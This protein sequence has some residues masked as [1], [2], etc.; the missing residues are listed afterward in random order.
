MYLSKLAVNPV[1]N[2][3]VTEITSRRVAENKHLPRREIKQ[4]LR[5]YDRALSATS[6]GIVIAD[7]QQP[8]YPLIYCNPAFEKLTGYSKEEVLGFNCRFLQ[9]VDSDPEVIEEIRSCLEQKKDCAVVVKNYRKDGTPFWNELTISP[10]RD[11]KG[12]V[13]HFIGVQNDITQRKLAEEALQKANQELEQR[14]E[15]RTAALQQANEMLKK[16]IAERKRVEAALRESEARFRAIFERAAIG[17]ALIDMD[18]RPVVS[19]PALQKMLGYSSAELGSMTFAEFTHPNDVTNDSEEYQQL[20]TGN[21]E[22]YQKSKRYYR[23]DRKLVWGN[24]SISLVRDSKGKPQFAV[25]MVENITKRKQAEVALHKALVKE[26]ELGEL[27]SKII[28]IT[29]HEFRTPLTTILSSAELLE[30]YSQEWNEAKKLKHIQRI[31]MTVSQMTRVLDDVLLL[32]KAEAGKLKFTP[33]PL[34]LVSFCYQAIEELRLG[35]GSR[36]LLNFFFDQKCEPALIDEKLLRYILSNLFSNAVKYSPEGSTINFELACNDRWVVLRVQD[37]GIGIPQEDLD[38]LFES[39]H[40]AR[41]VGNI[42]GS[43]LGLAIAKNCV[44]LHEGKIALESQVGVGTTVTVSL[45]LNP[46]QVS[47]V[48]FPPNESLTSD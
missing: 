29:S 12:R 17:I 18:G 34:D 43:G 23:K 14:V 4:M 33:Q 2:K 32:G 41:N 25:G 44:D 8:D 47:K 38:R 45:P 21:R 46:N 39:F 20:V 10:V 22:H 15:E 37:R 5:L 40:R 13:T 19:N 28:S 11:S 27:K 9:G 30:N 35:I 24:L 26:K 7:A 31:K 42:Q 1:D 36:H 6:N 48:D 3:Q 16:E